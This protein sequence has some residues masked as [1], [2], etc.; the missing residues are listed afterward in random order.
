LAYFGL[1]QTAQAEASLREMLELPSMPDP[2]RVAEVYAYAGQPDLAFE[3][4]RKA[5]DAEERQWC[6]RTGCRQLARQSPFLAPLHSDPRWKSWTESARRQD[7][8][9]ASSRRG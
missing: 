4:L 3:W 9:P 6:V 8:M 5:A 2:V 1:G 7:K